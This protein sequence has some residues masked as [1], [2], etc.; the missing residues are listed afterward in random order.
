[1][2]RWP[3]IGLLLARRLRNCPNSKPTLGQRLRFAGNVV[4]IFSREDDFALA[5]LARNTGKLIPCEIKVYYSITASD[6]HN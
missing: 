3:N 1:M 6:G 5:P 2:R 4:N